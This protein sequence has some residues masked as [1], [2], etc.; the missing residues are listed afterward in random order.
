MLDRNRRP[1]DLILT[2]RPLPD[3][4]GV[5][6]EVRLRKLLKFAARYLRLS[7]VWHEEHQE[8]EERKES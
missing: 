3:A 1:G 2:I 4:E 8:T 7:C 6:V 5:P